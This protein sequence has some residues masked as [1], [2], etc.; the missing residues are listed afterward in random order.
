[1]REDEGKKAFAVAPADAGEIVERG[2]TGEGDGVD[3]VVAH[4]SASAEE[5]GFALGELNGMG[6]VAAVG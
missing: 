1:M 5:P 2:S 6:F 4:E 3:P